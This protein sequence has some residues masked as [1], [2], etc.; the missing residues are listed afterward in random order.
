MSTATLVAKVLIYTEKCNFSLVSSASVGLFWL[1]LQ[2]FYIFSEK[3]R[4]NICEICK[5]F[6]YLQ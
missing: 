5:L 2:S 4:K 1:H 3:N 6:L